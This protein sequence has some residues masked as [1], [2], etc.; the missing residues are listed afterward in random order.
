MRRFH[1]EAESAA[2]LDHANIVPIYEVGAH[3]GQHYFSM[4]LIEGGSLAQAITDCGS[5]IA[6]WEKPAARLLAQVARAVHFAHQRGILHR[7]LKPAN[8]LLQSADGKPA[9]GNPES[10]IPMVTDFGLA[11]RVHGEPAANLTQ[12]GAIVGT[13]SYM[14]PEQVRAEKQ[15]TTAVDVYSLGAILYEMLTARQ[16]FQAK[17]PFDTLKQVVEGEPTAPRSIRANVDRDLETICLKCMHKLPERR[18]ES[19]S[20]FADDLESWLRGEAIVARPITAAERLVKWAR[21]RPAVAALVAVTF[22]ATLTLLVSGI[23]FNARLQFLLGEVDNKQSALDQANKDAQRDRVRAKGLLLSAHATAALPT[24]PAL[25]MLLGIEGAK[26]NPGLVAN[27]TLQATLDECLE[28]R[29]LYGHTDAVLAVAFSPD[30]RR[31]VT[32]S[33]DRTARIWDTATGQT[34]FILKGFEGYVTMVAFSP[35][36]N[37]VL[38]LAPRPDRSVVVWDVATGKELARIKLTSEWDPRFQGPS[39]WG[40]PEDAARHEVPFTNPVEFRM[41]NFSPDGSSILTA[42]GEYPDFTARVWDAATGEERVVLQGHE[43]PVV[44]ALYNAGG[45]LIVTASLDK[46]ARIWDAKTG[47]LMHVLNG[48][49]GAVMSAAFSPY[50]RVLTIGE[51]HTFAFTPEKGYHATTLNVDTLERV[52]GRIWDVVTGKQVAALEWPQGVTGV[53]GRGAFTPNGQFVV[54]AGWRYFTAGGSGIPHV[55]DAGANQPKETG[56]H[57]KALEGPH[58]VDVGAFHDFQMVGAGANHAA[59]VWDILWKRESGTLRGHEGPVLAVAASSD[60]RLIATASEDKTARIWVAPPVGPFGPTKGE[61]FD[62]SDAWFGKGGQLFVMNRTQ[63]EDPFWRTEAG[64]KIDALH[65]VPKRKARSS[66]GADP[67]LQVVSV[68]TSDVFCWLRATA[69]RPGFTTPPPVRKSHSFS[70][71]NP[72]TANPAPTSLILNSTTTAVEFTRL[73]GRAWSICSTPS[74]AWN[75]WRKTPA[76]F[77]RSVQ[78][79][80]SWSR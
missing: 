61:W 9:V 25:A 56:K 36:G 58:G 35:D 17:T 34:V 59:V 49:S 24:N 71:A 18:Y 14:A 15:L 37:R 52:A 22:A 66:A 60:G 72:P 51:G 32:A 64:K 54:T 77:P 75:S 62:R 33:K 23:L 41:A 6:D 57:L 11:K 78:T 46:T 73:P 76:I 4:K 10:A 26:R 28:R 7:D 42:F 21:R 48:H 1:A 31:L 40:T 13:P 44:S 65:P 80:G 5:T 27:N 39:G 67:G 45:N 68:P 30:G 12:P 74:R 50:G 79:A 38:T 43:G 47:K 55:W 63:R 19:A 16:P 70:P 53:V 8:I 2:G 69:T 29:T 20:A 3:E